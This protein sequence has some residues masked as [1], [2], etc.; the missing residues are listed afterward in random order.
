MR[1]R[2]CCT[3]RQL[4]LRGH[5]PWRADYCTGSLSRYRQHKLQEVATQTLNDLFS[6]KICSYLPCEQ[7]ILI[8]VFLSVRPSV[9]L[10]FQ[11]TMI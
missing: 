2:V 9:T 4:P 6:C 3:T 11:D 5:S 10:F 8:S 7:G 1:P